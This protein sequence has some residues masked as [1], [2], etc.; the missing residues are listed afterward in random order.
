MKAHKPNSYKYSARHVDYKGESY[1]LVSFGIQNEEGDKRVVTIGP[2]SLIDAFNKRTP[3]WQEGDCEESRI[4]ET[5]FEYHPAYLLVEP[6]IPGILDNFHDDVKWTYWDQ[7]EAEFYESPEKAAAIDILDEFET[8]LDEKDITIPSKD[9]EGGEEEAR[10]YGSEY[11][12][13]EDKIASILRKFLSL[14][15][16]SVILEALNDF[17]RWFEE[18]DEADSEKINEIK[19]AIEEVKRR[20]PL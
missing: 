11:Y 13:L 1:P 12:A 9:R 10:L 6:D 2:E 3:S 18:N 8:L 14:E 7:Q 19:K 4:D 16:Q 20:G 15:N 5:I 17:R